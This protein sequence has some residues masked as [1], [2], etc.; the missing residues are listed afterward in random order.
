MNTGSVTL[1]INSVLP[2]RVLVFMSH[3]RYDLLLAK[4]NFEPFLENCQEDG[5]SFHDDAVWAE[6][7]DGEEER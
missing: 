7:R 1:F 6:T 3:Y 2:K 5:K 4:F